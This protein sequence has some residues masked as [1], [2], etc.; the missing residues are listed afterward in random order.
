M[1]FDDILAN[2]VLCFRPKFLKV[3]FAFA[4]Q[5][6]D[7]V[8]QRVKPNVGDVTVVERKF[9]SPGKP[10]LGTGD[11][12]VLERL[13]QHSKHFVLISLGPDELRMRFDVAQ[14]LIL[15]LAHPKEIILFLDQF[16]LGQMVWTFTVN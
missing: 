8:D 6:A 12:E 3:A 1:R 2:E 14:Q 15:V 16:G 13:A 5:S 11:A 10:A 7:V 4:F 9:D